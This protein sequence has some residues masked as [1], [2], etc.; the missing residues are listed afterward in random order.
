MQEI[1]SAVMGFHKVLI[2]MLITHLSAKYGAFIVSL[3]NVAI[4]KCW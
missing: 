4:L 1:L 2:S 3:D